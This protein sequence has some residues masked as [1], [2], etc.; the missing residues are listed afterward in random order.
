MIGD[1]S[2]EMIAFY[3]G[4]GIG[5]LIGLKI[6]LLIIYLWLKKK[7]YFLNK[8]NKASKKDAM[9]SA[10]ATM[11]F[12][13]PS[14]ISC[15]ASEIIT[16]IKKLTKA[17]RITPIT[18]VFPVTIPFQYEKINIKKQIV[19]INAN[20]P[21]IVPINFRISSAVPIKFSLHKSIY[22]FAFKLSSWVLLVQWYLIDLASMISSRRTQIILCDILFQ[23]VKGKKDD[24]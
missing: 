2:E 7:G 4:L 19:S 9:A 3:L 18:T 20:I 10:I 17:N 13:I 12:T 22:H 24:E 8:P 11:A 14:I 5:I 23:N 21:K 16:P 15:I 1:T 6:M